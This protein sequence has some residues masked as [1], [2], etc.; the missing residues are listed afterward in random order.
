MKPRSRALALLA[1]AV[2]AFASAADPKPEEGD[3]PGWRGPSRTGISAD[4]GL[5][6]EW[7]TDGPKLLL[8]ATGLGGGYSTVAISGGRIFVTG[9]KGQKPGAGGGFGKGGFGK[10]KGKGKG[11]FGG[12]GGGP[13]HDES[14]I[15]LDA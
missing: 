7:P 1:L 12:F 15:C 10:G 5:L 8:K 9:A 2:C 4:T 14:L 6:K 3:W 13:S 11:G